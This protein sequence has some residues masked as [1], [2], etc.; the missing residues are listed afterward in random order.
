[1]RGA[2]PGSAI[3]RAAAA[4]AAEPG[5]G[6]AHYLLGLQRSLA[7]EW[8]GAAA[9]LELALGRELPGPAFVRNAARQLAI[10]A[11]RARDRRRLELA[12]ATLSSLA[13][14]DR[15]LA[16]DWRAR[17]T[18]DDTGKL[19]PQGPPASAAVEP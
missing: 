6:F 10:V 15:W 16:D 2:P 9:E 3:E 1:M 4:V 7:G 17:I 11:Y 8:P 5:L 18:F 19:P 14:G 13:S 12:I